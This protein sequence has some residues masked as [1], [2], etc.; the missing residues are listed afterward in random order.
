MIWVVF[1]PE[2]KKP[3]REANNSPPSNVEFKNAWNEISIL[4]THLM[5]WK[6]INHKDINVYYTFLWET[7]FMKCLVTN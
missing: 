1:Y 5:L 2:I 6:L 4:S 3:K 7:S